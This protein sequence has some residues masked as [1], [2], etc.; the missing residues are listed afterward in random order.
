MPGVKHKRN[1]VMLYIKNCH[2]RDN[3]SEQLF[4]SGDKQLTMTLSDSLK[5]DLCFDIEKYPA[6]FYQSLQ[7]NE[8][9]T[10]VKE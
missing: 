10:T 6:K 9:K 2:H 5:H 1:V 7:R 3:I 4:L 8:K